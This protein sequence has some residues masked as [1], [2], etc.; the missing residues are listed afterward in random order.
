MRVVGEIEARRV[1]RA[2]AHVDPERTDFP[3]AGN[4]AH[5]EENRDQPGEEQQESELPTATTIR[6]VAR[7]RG[8]A[9]WRCRY[10]GLRSH[11]RGRSC[12]GGGFGSYGRGGGGGDGFHSHRRAGGDGLLY[13]RLRLCTLGFDRRTRLSR[14][15]STRQ[16]LQ[17]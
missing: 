7:A 15:R 14:G 1:A 9:D 17:Q 2:P 4:R 11:R 16:G 3:V 8:L 6:L 10:D 12:G 13:G 5:Q